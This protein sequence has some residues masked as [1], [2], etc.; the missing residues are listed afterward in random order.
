M[1]ITKFIGC[2]MLLITLIASIVVIIFIFIDIFSNPMWYLE[3]LLIF[4]LFFWAFT[5]N[6]LLAD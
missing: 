3:F 4:V 1:K 6:K 5:M 2:L